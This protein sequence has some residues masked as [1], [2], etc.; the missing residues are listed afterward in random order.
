L[1]AGGRLPAAWAT[2]VEEP[3]GDGVRVGDVDPPS[4]VGQSS[5]AHKET[6][7]LWGA[8]ASG[9]RGVSSPSARSV[10][11]GGGGWT[12]ARG[13]WAQMKGIVDPKL[14]DIVCVNFKFFYLYL[15]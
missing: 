14:Q 15:M 6:M 13:C 1:P 12:P 9:G 8:A 3:I 5:P 7:T 11:I 4:V 10:V 2:E